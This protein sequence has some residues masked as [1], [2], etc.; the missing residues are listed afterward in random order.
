MSTRLVYVQE[1][2]RSLHIR[3]FYKLI[4]TVALFDTVCDCTF[5]QSPYPALWLS[6]SSIPSIH[7]Y[8]F[9]SRSTTFPLLTGLSHRIPYDL[10]Y[11]I[12]SLSPLSIRRWQRGRR[13][14][15]FFI[16]REHG[17]RTKRQLVSM[18]KRYIK[19]SLNRKNELSTGYMRYG[20]GK[21]LITLQWRVSL[22]RC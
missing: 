18:V 1:W 15:N 2:E 8:T 22:I 17:A 6:L 20:I 5:R 3:L 7:D 12:H 16:S 14:I 21:Q 19:N 10:P 11:L 9:S 4:M 13:L